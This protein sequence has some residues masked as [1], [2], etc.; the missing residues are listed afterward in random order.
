MCHGPSGAG[1]G[2]TAA[3]LNPKPRDFHDKEWQK[4]TSDTQMHDAVVGGGVAV[5]KSPLMPPNPDLANKPAVVDQ[6]VK[7]VRGYGS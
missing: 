1:D 7:I 6:L 2:P 4:S 5:G 3:T